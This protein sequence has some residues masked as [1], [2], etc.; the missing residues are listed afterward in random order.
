MKG[1]NTYRMSNGER[2]LKS[3]INRKIRDAKIKKIE[4]FLD[5]HGYLFCEDCKTTQTTIDCS[6]T[7]SVDECQKTGKSELAW[8]IDNIKLRCR[9]CHQKHDNNLI[10]P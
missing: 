6:H 9:K 4:Q 8:D 2:V 10:N 5:K 3:V 1:Q 7:I